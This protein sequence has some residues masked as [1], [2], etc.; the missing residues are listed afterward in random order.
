MATT[1]KPFAAEE[2]ALGGHPDI[3]SED[4]QFVLKSLLATYQLI[5]EEELK[6]TRAPEQLKKEVEGGPQSRENELTLANRIFDKFLTEEVAMRLLPEAGRKLLGP[7]EN[8]RACLQQVRCSLILGW[9]VCRGP[10]T[11][12][13]FVYYV[14]QYWIC[15][16][17]SLGSPVS[18]PPT[19]VQRKDFQ[20]LAEA[21]AKAYK[22]YLTDQLASVEF[23]AGIPDEVLAGKIN[24]TEG[25]EDV[26]EIFERLLTADAAQALLG[27][28]T[29]AVSRR[30]PN[31]WFCRC[32]M[33]AAAC[34][35]CCLARARNLDEVFSCLEYYFRSL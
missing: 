19:E 32:W 2:T 31:F 33:V 6:R 26:C 1:K 30:D 3:H 10:R 17:K 29:F 20:V 24:P 25:Q 8:W 12:R 27:R 11:F 14:Y 21:L 22:P 13:A 7:V 5:L 4:F 35:G 23:P 28:E 15:V 18:S 34:F 16:R 9:L